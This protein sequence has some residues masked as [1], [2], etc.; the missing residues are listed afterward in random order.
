MTGCKIDFLKEP[1]QSQPPKPLPFSELE[2]DIIDKEIETM[3]DKGVIE[4]SEHETGEFLSNIFL[5]PKK[6]GRFRVILNLRHFNEFVDSDHFKMDSI[7]T[8]INLMKKDCYMASIDLRD[9]YY[10]VPIAEHDRKYLKFIWKG[11][12]YSYT[13]LAMGLACAPRKFVKLL[14]PVFSYLHSKGHVSSGYLDDTFLEGDDYETCQKNVEATVDLLE[15]LGFF[16]HVEKSMMTPSKELE[17]LGFKLNSENMTVSLGKDKHDKLEGKIKNLMTNEHPTIREV[18][19]VIGSMVSYLPGVEFGNLY[20]RQLEME[21]IIALKENKGNY[22]K[23]MTL[24]QEAY[25]QM[26]WWL[27]EAKSCP[28]IIIKGDPTHIIGTDASLLGWGASMGQNK[29]GGRWSETEKVKHINE[30]ELI[31][32]LFGLKSLCTELNNTHILIK[33]DN[34]TAVAY[35]L[36]MGGCKSPN[37]NKIAREIWAWA[38]QRNIWLSITYI[39]GVLNVEPDELSRHFD[40]N[41]EW[42]LNPVLFREIQ[43][44]YKTDIDLFAS[45]LNKQLDKFVSWQPDPNAIAINAFSLNWNKYYSYIFA[46]FSMLGRVLAKLEQDQAEAIVIAPWWAAQSWFP[47]LIRM[48]IEPPRLLPRGKKQLTLPFN[49]EKIHPLWRKMNLLV[50]PLSGR[51]CKTRAFRQSLKKSSFS[52]GERGHKNNIQ[53]IYGDGHTIAVD[54]VLIPITLM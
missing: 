47:K 46:P 53:R 3:L 15:K 6:D 23:R 8:C 33:S 35:V 19:S 49:R 36:N 14:K 17:H 7:V 10:S 21:K 24:S 45:R 50:C 26:T 25:E 38:R 2:C 32:I 22:E 42:M 27:D 31:A 48:L 1:Y 12:L 54:G 44:T 28:T 18:S 13:C 5:R 52:H 34:T 37:C 43:K 29:C 9:A 4:F 51:S 30:L 20:Y 11:Q 16:V 39:E 40:D 41:T